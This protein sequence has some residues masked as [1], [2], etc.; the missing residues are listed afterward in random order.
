[1]AHSVALGDFKDGHTGAGNYA[2]DTA[3]I[4]S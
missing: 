2:Y 3:S 1:M 4:I